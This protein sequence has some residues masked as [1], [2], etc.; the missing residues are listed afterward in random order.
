MVRDAKHLF[1]TQISNERMPDPGLFTWDM[2]ADLVYADG[3]LAD[4]FGLDPKEAERGLPVQTYLDRVHPDD[5]A[6]L[7]KQI[8][9]AI[10]AQHPTV[11]NY[12]SQKSD[13]SYVKVSAFGRCFRDREDNPIYYA[14][15]VVPA[16]TSAPGR[17]T[18]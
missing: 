6:T 15:V 1:V 16:E 18:H 7:A 4:L 13:G 10:V 9:D 5:V 14:G 11:Q 12:R 17:P 3:A 8:S 2:N